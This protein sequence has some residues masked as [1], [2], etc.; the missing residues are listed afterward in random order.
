[1]IAQL[2]KPILTIV[3]TALLFSN[4]KKTVDEPLVV[5][6]Y[7]K[8]QVY[9][10]AVDAPA[11][12]FQVDGKKLNTDSLAYPKGIFYQ[13]AELTTGKKNIYKIMAAKSNQAISIDSLTMNTTDVGYSV[14]VYQ[15]KDAAKTIRSFYSPDNLLAPPAGKAKV[16]L[17]QLISDFNVN[18]DVQAVAPGGAATTA[19]DFQNVSF[20]KVTDFIN[21]AKGTYDLKFKISGQTTAPV[22][23]TGVIIEEGKIY[24]LI[25]RGLSNVATTATKNRGPAL[26]IVTNK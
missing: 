17:V 20:P 14:F 1:M 8:I 4:C 3:L 25:A 24:T 6:T 11:I 12:D 16:R 15:D 21:L 23:I 10:A 19:S 26:S 9:N 5:K 22:T 13:D 2:T 7:G 18:V